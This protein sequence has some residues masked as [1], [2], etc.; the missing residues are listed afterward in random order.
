MCASCG[1]GEPNAQHDDRR[2]ITAD[3]VKAA[4]E[5]AGISPAE[6]ARN[7]SQAVQQQS[8]TSS[9]SESATAD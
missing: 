1:C 4:A 3:Q 6:A 7:I 2:H 9:R 5:A 8:G